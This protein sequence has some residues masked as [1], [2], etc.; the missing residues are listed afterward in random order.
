M[1]SALLSNIR[2]FFVD[3]FCGVGIILRRLAYFWLLFLYEVLCTSTSSSAVGIHVAFLELCAELGPRLT[4]AAL[5]AHRK[6]TLY[7]GE[8]GAAAGEASWQGSSLSCS[9]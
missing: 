8:S 3:T 9:P 1:R 2:I 6:G 7:R 5:P 4:I